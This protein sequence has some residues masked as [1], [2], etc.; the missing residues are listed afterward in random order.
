MTID[1]NCDVGERDDV[2]EERILPFVTSANVACGGHAGDERTMERTLR[3]ARRYGVMCG[4]HPGYPDAASFGR[5]QLNMSA[6]ALADTVFEQVA[7]LARVAERIG[8]ALTHVKPHGALY[9]TAA[10]DAETARAVAE[11]VARWRRD[12]VLV[13]LAG[14]VM[15]EI[16]RD[17]GFAVAAEGFADRTYEADGTLRSRKLP[18]AV[19]EEPPAAAEQAVRLAHQGRAR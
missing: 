3:L 16:W 14:G 18:G 8:I 7:R 9:N 15:L 12:V 4:A 19:I 1:I 10:R 5:E 6:A 2:P 11:G 17:A 13:G